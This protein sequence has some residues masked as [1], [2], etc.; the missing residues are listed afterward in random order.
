[1]LWWRLAGGCLL[2]AFAL[3]AGGL[4]VARVFFASYGPL[5][6]PPR[7][8]ATFRVSCT[9]GSTM[10]AER[11]DKL[12]GILGWRFDRKSFAGLQ[13][14]A[15]GTDRIEVAG[16]L[17]SAGRR[18]LRE[19]FEKARDK[20]AG[21]NLQPSQVQDYLAASPDKRRAMLGGLAP[22][23]VT[24]LSDLGKAHDAEAKAA[25]ALAA[26][27][28]AGEEP[29]KQAEAENALVS[30]RAALRENDLA[31]RGGNVPVPYLVSVL[32]YY[33]GGMAQ[34]VPEV[35]AQAR[36]LAN[37][38]HETDAM[39]AEHPDR[40]QDIQAVVS[41]YTAMA[42]EGRDLGDSE[43][44]ARLMPAAGAL[45]FRIAVGPR[46][47]PIDPEE[48]KVYQGL[49]TKDGPEEVRRAAM[50]YAWFPI[51][52]GDQRQFTGLITA[53]Y[54]GRDFVLLSNGQGGIMVPQGPGSE[55][56]L[57]EVY[58]GSD[59]IGRPAI[60]FK[61]DQAGARTFY[62]LTSSHRGQALAILL[63]DE[64][65]SAPN[66]QSAI[67][68]RGQITGTFTRS[69]VEEYVWLLQ[70]G[71]I[72][73]R[74]IFDLTSLRNAPAG[75]HPNARAMRTW[76]LGLGA[77]AVAALLLAFLAVVRCRL[78]SFGVW[79]ILAGVSAG[80]WW[81][82]VSWNTYLP[83]HWARWA[84][85]AMTLPL[86]LLVIVWASALRAARRGKMEMADGGQRPQT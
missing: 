34:R 42:R 44:L 41:A 81:Y 47:A 56:R 59:G 54:A 45:G 38:A 17:A 28:A 15:V 3:L 63:N 35:G 39:K 75:E 16:P 25:T 2:A 84:M 24:R 26:A 21:G 65:F 78:V 14:Q 4:V 9:D 43:E 53:R 20:L 27:K 67:S 32:W 6:I 68:D 5:E 58:H 80:A 19:A 60:D 64:V 82:V 51:R 55:W 1:M 11:M 33:C 10:N 71:A 12:I 76:L 36:L 61:L 18:R 62:S 48:V 69:E 52:R 73:G 46:G 85:I 79:A 23:Q 70:E 74:T 29:T 57:T 37:L 30:A 8:V 31:V 13:W 72:W 22:H 86:V 49:L 50:P 7:W 66:I 83:G 77:A 40:A